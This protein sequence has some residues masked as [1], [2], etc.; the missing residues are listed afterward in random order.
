M[1]ATLLTY[2]R[3]SVIEQ[4]TLLIR[5]G[6]INPFEYHKK[7]IG[8]IR[9]ERIRCRG[10]NSI[11]RGLIMAENEELRA[12]DHCGTAKRARIEDMYGNVLCAPCAAAEEAAEDEDY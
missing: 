8:V 9:R 5:D 1:R 6:N 12:C 3:L 4:H 10:S 2:S 11:L 7:V